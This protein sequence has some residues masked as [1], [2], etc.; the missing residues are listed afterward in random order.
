MPLQR[1]FVKS[2]RAAVGAEHCLDSPEADLVAAGCPG[3]IVQIR[4]SLA[5]AG[6]RM[7]VLHPVELLARS[8]GLE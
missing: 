2:V 8:Y 1:S 3:C 5:R 4:A 7:E 6:S